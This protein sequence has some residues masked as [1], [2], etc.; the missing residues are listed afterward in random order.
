MN[1]N[2]FENFQ[3]TLTQEQIEE[4]LLHWLQKGFR[5]IHGRPPLV[6]GWTVFF[7]PLCMIGIRPGQNPG[8]WSVHTGHLLR[9]MG[10][11]GTLE[12]LKRYFETA[13]VSQGIFIKT[14]P[15]QHHTAIEEPLTFW[16]KL[17]SMIGSARIDAIWDPYLDEK[18]IANFRDLAGLGCNF[19]KALKLLTAPRGRLSRNFLDK[20]DKEFGLASELKRGN[21]KHLRLI[22]LSD[23][24]CL[25][26]DFSFGKEQDGT[27]TVVDANPK[28]I[29]FDIAWASATPIT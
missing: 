2:V 24:R 21:G 19:S 3:P 23:G 1:K 11:V 22:F 10:E 29:L 20:F 15:T 12:E 9:S 17:K 27:I 28:R 13:C 8:H 5:V 4:Y 14:L 16:I 6:D 25:S 26:P 18:A 7:R